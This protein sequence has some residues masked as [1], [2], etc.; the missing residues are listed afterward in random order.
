MKNIWIGIDPGENTGVAVWNSTDKVFEQLRTLS[1][2]ESIFFLIDYKRLKDNNDIALNI[3][4]E[5]VTQNKPT[6]E[7]GANAKANTRISQNVGMNKNDCKR[8]IEF[9]EMQ[10]LSILRIRPNKNSNTKLNQQ[11]FENLTKCII[12]GSQH[13]RDAGMLIFG[14]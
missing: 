12:K 5:D 14:R 7:R 3:V 6:F 4:I 11:S 9:C 13:S 8:M 2:W 1:F 10:D